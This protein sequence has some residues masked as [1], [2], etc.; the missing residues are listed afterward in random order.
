MKLNRLDAKFLWIQE[1]YD[2][3][4]ANPISKCNIIY[5]FGNP[6]ENL[7]ELFWKL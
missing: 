4:N 2:F 7:L 6:W 1:I 5:G 3:A